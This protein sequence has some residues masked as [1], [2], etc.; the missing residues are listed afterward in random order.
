M[1]SHV[2]HFNEETVSINSATFASFGN[3]PTIPAQG[4]KTKPHHVQNLCQQDNN[5]T[6]NIQYILV[7]HTCKKSLHNLRNLNLPARTIFQYAIAIS[8]SKT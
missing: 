5:E 3:E 7:H 2:K 4:V 6:Y 8:R 1:T